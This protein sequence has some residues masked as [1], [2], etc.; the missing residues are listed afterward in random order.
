MHYIFLSYTH[1]DTYSVLSLPLS[2]SSSVFPS[3]LFIVRVC[4]PV[5]RV[6]GMNTVR[7]VVFW[8]EGHWC[9]DIQAVSSVIRLQINCWACPEYQSKPCGLTGYKYLTVLTIHKNIEGRAGNLKPCVTVI[10]FF[11]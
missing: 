3:P 11:S 10:S 4:P 7:L 6:P 5:Y 8:Y 1:T 2:M 9:P